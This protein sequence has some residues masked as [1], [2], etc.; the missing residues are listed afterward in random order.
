V[1]TVR[2]R[3]PLRAREALVWQKFGGWTGGEDPNLF[4]PRSFRIPRDGI[5]EVETPYRSYLLL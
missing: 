4:I 1:D 3:P 2:A 5:F